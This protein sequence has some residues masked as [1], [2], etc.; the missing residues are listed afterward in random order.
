ML[1]NNILNLQKIDDQYE[2]KIKLEY[3]QQK[4]N[5]DLPIKFNIGGEVAVDEIGMHHVNA[6]E[7]IIQN[8]E[9]VLQA[10]VD[11]IYDN[12]REWQ[13]L[14]GCDEMSK[15]ERA[16]FMPDIDSKK[17]LMSLI[18]PISVII[19]DIEKDGIAYY[20]VQFTCAWDEE[21]NL[22]VMLHKNRIVEVGTDDVAF[23][24]WIAEKDYENILEEDEKSKEHGSASAISDQQHI[25]ANTGLMIKNVLNLQKVD[26]QFLGKIKLEHWQQEF[27][28]RLPIDLNIG[29][30]T[31]LDKIE[32]HH[33]KACEYICK[34]EVEILQIIIDAIYENYRKWQVEYGYATM[35]AEKRK[36]SMPNIDNIARI[37]PM[38]S[39]TWLI[40][41]DVEKDDIA[42]YGVKF[43]C[44]WDTEHNLGVMLH[45][46]RVVTIGTEDKAY[47]AKYAK[48]DCEGVLLEEKDRQMKGEKQH[49]SRI[50]K[51]LR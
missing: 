3:W 28:G 9:E 47:L 43:L 49:Q 1:N 5:I 19:L 38:I 27:M 14:Y 51:R 32:A 11:A 50:F 6:C 33:V 34:H 35:P 41:H 4:F 40:I 22:G 36:Y 2:G 24:S 8:Q 48:A 13:V 37:R 29:G 10:I 39:P 18:L 20:G 23:L 21:H 12:Y 44:T 25:D 42:Y 31:N 45:K 16:E 7:Y 30:E 15:E 17:E 46:N 26:G